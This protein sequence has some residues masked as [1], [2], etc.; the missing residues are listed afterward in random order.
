MTRMSE[1]LILV[2]SSVWI[3][4]FYGPNQKIVEIIDSAVLLVS[5]L[6]L[7][8]VKRTLLRRGI[9]RD[10]VEKAVG[11]IRY[12][13]RV[14][15]VSRSIADSAAE[16]SFKH[17]MSTADALIYASA[18]EKKAVL[19]TEDNDFKLLKDVRLI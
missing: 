17:D 5:V 9:Q 6:S 16:F 14:V 8:E 1:A 4:Y 19:L 18:Q 13:A 3:D 12:R 11:F 10:K 2:D 15:D 7:F